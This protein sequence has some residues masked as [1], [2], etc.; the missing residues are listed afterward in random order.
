MADQ[1]TG[2]PIRTEA[3]GTDERVHTKIVDYTDPG[4][5]DKQVEVSE[6]LAHIRNFGAD[7]GA[8]KRQK[9]TSEQGH[10][11][12]DGIYDV[13]NNTDPSNVG[14][15]A[16]ARGATPGDSDQTERL[17][18][19]VSGTVHALDIALHDEDGVPF[20]YA[21]PLPV[22]P[23]E[24]E[25]T[26]IHDY[27]AGDSIASDATSNHDYV[28]ADGVRFTLYGVH[29]SASGKMKVE[30]QIGDGA[31]SEAFTTKAVSF[32]STANPQGD[33]DFYRVP[34]AVVGTVNGTT[35]RVIRTNLDNQAQNL[36]STIIGVEN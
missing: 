24:N 30:L 11:S 28:V 26:E 12:V 13:S 6:K 5:T 3:D 34:I 2:L 17:T 7:P 33:V 1:D 31:A 18:A 20:S 14:I 29:A 9:R 27:D 32:N 10:D 8:T 4:G 21:N 36:Y 23:Q 22:A 19:A 15:V 25:G 16:H 35:I